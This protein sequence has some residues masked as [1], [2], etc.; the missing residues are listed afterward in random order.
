M[1]VLQVGA[2]PAQRAAHALAHGGLAGAQ[3]AGDLVIGPLVEDSRAQR[4]TLIVGQPGQRAVEVGAQSLDAVQIG[5]RRLDALQ[6]Q[7]PAHAVLGVPA[8]VLIK[9][10]VARDREQ[11]RRGRRPTRRA[12]IVD[13]DERPRE[14]LG[15]QI[16][17]QFTRAAPSQERQHERAVALEQR[18]ERLGV[19]TAGRAQEL[20]V[21][22]GH[23]LRLTQPL[24]RL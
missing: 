5:R 24:P 1:I 12:A 15:Q 7:P 23:P 3:L 2:Q 8:T 6:R 4:S 21:R 22:S 16:R 17:G 19:A 14:R 20:V 11:P 10:R 9:E 13:R 18:T